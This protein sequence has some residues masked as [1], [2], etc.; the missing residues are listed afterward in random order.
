MFFRRVAAAPQFFSLCWGST[1]PLSTMFFVVRHVAC[2]ESETSQSV[3]NQNKNV[4]VMFLLGTR[5]KNGFVSRWYTLA[6]MSQLFEKKVSLEHHAV[7]SRVEVVCVGR[8][9][10]HARG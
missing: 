8:V 3:N 1:T 4:A 10:L 5:F 6:G 2:G 7:G 9:L